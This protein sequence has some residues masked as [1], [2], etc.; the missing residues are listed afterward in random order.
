MLHEAD[1]EVYA[2]PQNGETMSTQPLD[3]GE[4]IAELQALHMA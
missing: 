4:L 1:I 3:A 2:S